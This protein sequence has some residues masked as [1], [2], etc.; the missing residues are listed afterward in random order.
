MP[1]L[2]LP[3]TLLRTRT[4]A[5]HG[6]VQGFLFSIHGVPASRA[7]EKSAVTDRISHHLTG[8]MDGNTTATSRDIR[9]DLGVIDHSASLCIIRWDLLCFSSAHHFLI[10]SRHDGR[11]GRT[12][13]YYAIT[14]R[15]RCGQL[16]YPIRTRR[17]NHAMQCKQS[18]R[19]ISGVDCTGA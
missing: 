10:K 12:A 16:S 4:P 5:T 3:V 17:P 18:A 1:C 6:L 7:L 15:M 14:A 9:W 13:H 8:S 2:I 19:E 11:L